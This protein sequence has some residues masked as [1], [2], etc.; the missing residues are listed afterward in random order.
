MK[1]MLTMSSSTSSL[2]SSISCTSRPS[3]RRSRLRVL[4]ARGRAA[5]RLQSH[6]EQ[7]V[8]PRSRRAPSTW[9]ARR[10]AL[11]SVHR[12]VPR[13]RRR[14]TR[15]HRPR[16]RL[17]RRR[18]RASPP[19]RARAPRPS[20][21]ARHAPGFNEPSRERTDARAHE[22]D[23]GV[24]DRLAHAPDLTVAALVDAE[25]DRGGLT[26]SLH[27]RDARRRGATVVELDALAAA[28]ARWPGVGSPSTSARYFF[29][30]PKL[31]WVRRWVRSPS[32][33]S[34]S[35]PSVS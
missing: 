35:R 15:P 19:R 8:S 27:H 11:Q 4:V 16:H 1:M 30:T 12:P 13:R 22:P 21:S 14:A 20:V 33:V 28:R 17:R 18:R 3:W 9:T 23:H 2:R 10:P 5:Q 24:P 34:S 25:L 26:V 6:R 32:F 7:Q 29:S 31:G